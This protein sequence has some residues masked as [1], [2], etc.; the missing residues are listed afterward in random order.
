SDLSQG[1]EKKTGPLESVTGLI[2]LQVS[3]QF[4]LGYSYD[5]TTTAINSNTHEIMLNYIF[6]KKTDKILSPRYF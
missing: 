3:P 5:F 4:Q 1:T 2:A 6:N